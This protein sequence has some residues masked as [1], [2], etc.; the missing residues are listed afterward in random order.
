MLHIF[1]EVFYTYIVISEA[2]Y[3]RKAVK[4]T[5]V[6]SGQ[7]IVQTIYII[8]KMVK[9]EI[10]VLIIAILHHFKEKIDYFLKEGNLT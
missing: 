3:L 7:K 1:F 9:Q 6:T 2:T 5:K 4:A 8:N 10:T